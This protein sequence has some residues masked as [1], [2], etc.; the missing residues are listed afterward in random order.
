MLLRKMRNKC[1]TNEKGLFNL[2]NVDIR[3]NERGQG[4]TIFATRCSN[5]TIRPYETIGSI[6]VLLYIPLGF[7]ECGSGQ[8]ANL[9]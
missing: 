1:Y 3:L 8:N 9:L 2:V 5:F 4:T 7:V 6:A